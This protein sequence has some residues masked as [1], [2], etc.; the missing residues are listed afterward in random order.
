MPESPEP[1]EP[2]PPKARTRFSIGEWYGVGF[3]KLS[4]KTRV[5]WAKR[6]IDVDGLTGIACP[7]SDRKCNKKGGV[8]SIRQYSGVSGERSAVLI[9]TPA[10]VCPNRFGEAGGVVS[11]VSKTLL[12]T[13]SP[14]VIGEVGFLDRFKVATSSTTNLSNKT[15]GGKDGTEDQD[16]SDFIGRIDSI[17]IHPKKKPMEWCALEI[18]AVYFSGG[19]MRCEFAAISESDGSIRFPARQRRPDWRSSGPKRLL[20][21]LQTKVPTISRWGKKM[22][23]VVD[24]PF[25]SELIGL[26]R[27]KHLSNSEIVWFVMDYR[28]T[29]TGWTL[30][31]G[32]VVTTTLETSVKALMGGTPLSKE[33]FELQLIRKIRA[34]SPGHRLASL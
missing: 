14:L 32:E 24:R 23:V 12:G 1:K 34:E 25:F 2:K 13:A 22:A 33:A 28:E 11:W 31:P 30:V 29:P 7:F 3:E 17:L 18:Q 4:P 5:Q 10:C 21:Q 9:D 20:S 16:D 8:C 19:S 27:Q 15:K 26:E 6:E